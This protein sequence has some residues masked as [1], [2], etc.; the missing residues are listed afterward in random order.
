[1]MRTTWKKLA[2]GLGVTGGLMLQA[3]TANVSQALSDAALAGLAAAV[4]D[5]VNVLV[6]NALR[7]DDDN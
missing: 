4:E 3:C 5:T 1:M 6:S 2:L 7:P